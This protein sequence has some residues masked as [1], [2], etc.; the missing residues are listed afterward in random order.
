MLKAVIVDANAI[1]RG[2]LNTV[3]TEG[4]YDVV[5]QTHT[6]AQGYALALKHQ[7]HFIC[8]ARE[9]VEDGNKVVE[10]LRAKLPKTLVFMVSGTIDAPTL[11]GALARG[12]HGFIVKPFKADTVLKTVR[13]TIIAV[14]R[15][16]QEPPASR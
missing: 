7:P 14:V 9:Q 8:I 4:S 10:E 16:H 1:S 12:V 2:L 6:S 5:G 15:K 11:Q 13:N 3:L